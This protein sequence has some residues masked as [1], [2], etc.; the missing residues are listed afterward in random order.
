MRERKWKLTPAGVVT[1]CQFCSVC[2][3]VGSMGGLMPLNSRVYGS[4]CWDMKRSWHTT[5]ILTGAP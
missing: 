4:E 2:E 3:Y 5:R 1:N